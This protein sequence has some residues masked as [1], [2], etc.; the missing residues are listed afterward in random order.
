MR[1]AVEGQGFDGPRQVPRLQRGEAVLSLRM[2]DLSS[3]PIKNKALAAFKGL[4]H[5]HTKLP[6]WCLRGSEQTAPRSAILWIS[7]LSALFK[8]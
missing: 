1:G 8:A 5:V 6:H 3:C 4:A 7:S 2:A